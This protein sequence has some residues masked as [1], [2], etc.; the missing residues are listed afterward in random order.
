[1][2]FVWQ[3]HNNSYSRPLEDVR[4]VNRLEVEYYTE[5]QYVLQ[6]VTYQK[7]TCVANNTNN[8][9]ISEWAEFNIT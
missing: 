9:M 8:S 1:M 2:I 7:F 5:K 6:S 3:G 4:L